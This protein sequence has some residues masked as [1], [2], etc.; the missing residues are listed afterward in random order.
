MGHSE[1]A[2]LG[3]GEIHR[4]I[5]DVHNLKRAARATSVLKANSGQI[6]GLV[7]S[8]HAAS[9]HP[10]HGK[11]GIETGRVLLHQV[12]GDHAAE[13]MSPSDGLGGRADIRLKNAEGVAI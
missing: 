1:I 3:R 6:Q 9:D 2:S 13:R 10:A 4:W 11:G 8:A 7:P 12:G 5:A